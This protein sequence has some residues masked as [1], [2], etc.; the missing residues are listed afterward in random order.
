MYLF[1]NAWIILSVSTKHV[2]VSRLYSKMETTSDLYEE[3]K[4][5]HIQTYRFVHGWS[6]VLS[7]QDCFCY[8]TQG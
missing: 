3:A 2:D 4:T 7:W 6:F 5:K 1:S 8:D